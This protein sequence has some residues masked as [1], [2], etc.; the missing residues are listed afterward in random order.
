MADL[1]KMMPLLVSMRAMCDALLL[2]IAEEQKKPRPEA[3]KKGLGL[4]QP[5]DHVH[6]V[7]P[8]FGASGVC[9]VCGET[10]AREVKDG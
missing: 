9:T 5:S 6:V 4:S 3:K 7:E 10:V 1:M 2:E 8:G